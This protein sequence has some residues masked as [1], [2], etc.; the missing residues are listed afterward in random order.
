MKA[1]TMWCIKLP[2]KK[3][4]LGTVS[5]K[6]IAAIKCVSHDWKEDKKNGFSCVRVQITEV[7]PK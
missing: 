2:N 6:R 7:K 3:L 1:K 4:S 5:E